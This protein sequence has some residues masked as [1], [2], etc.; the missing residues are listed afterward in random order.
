MRLNQELKSAKVDQIS[1]SM[2]FHISAY[3]MLSY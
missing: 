3:N 1:Y 2:D